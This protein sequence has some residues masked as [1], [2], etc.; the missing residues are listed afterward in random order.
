MNWSGSNNM[1]S[2]VGEK[3]KKCSSFTRKDKILYRIQCPRWAVLHHYYCIKGWCG[4]GIWSGCLLDSNL[5]R[6]SGHVQ[7]G[8]DTLGR[9]RIHRPGEVEESGWRE[10]IKSRF[11][12]LTQYSHPRLFFLFLPLLKFFQKNCLYFMDLWK[13]TTVKKR[14][15]KSV[16]TCIYDKNQYK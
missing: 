15:K 6:R 11:V 8:G 2:T 16:L 1:M 10:R 3:K 13:S 12:N 7:L 14:K 4:L 5:W 9:P